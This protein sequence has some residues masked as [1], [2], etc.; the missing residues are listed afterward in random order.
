MF[1]GRFTSGRGECNAI[2]GAWVSMQGRHPV[3][4]VRLRITGSGVNSRC[5]SL[6]G[7]SSPPHPYYTNSLMQYVPTVIVVSA[8]FFEP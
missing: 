6:R 4:Q 3:V 5:C 2:I 1:P 7:F 8:W